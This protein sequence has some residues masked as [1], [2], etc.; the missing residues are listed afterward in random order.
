MNND[1]IK[2]IVPAIFEKIEKTF[3]LK[4]KESKIIKEKLKALKDNR[5]T[6]EDANDFAIELGDILASAFSEN[7]STK[8]LPDGK[9]YYNIAKR[10]IEPNM[11]K[12]YE[13]VGDYARIVQ[14]S[15]NKQAQISIKA[16]K[17]EINQD[18]IDKLVDKISEYESFEKGKWLLNEPIKNFTQAIVDDTIKKNAD[19]HYKAG[20]RPKIIRRE[21]WNCC[22][23]CKAIAGV[24]D[25]QEVKNTGNDVF[26]RHRHCRCTVDYVPGDGSKQDVWSKQ[27][28]DVNVDDKNKRIDLSNKQVNTKLS[29]IARAKALE[30]GYDPLPDDEV[31]NILRKDSQQWIKNLSDNEIKAIKKYT[32]NGVDF[33]G[34]RL[35]YKING[36]IEGYYDPMD[37]N[38]EELIKKIYKNIYTGILKNR[39]D[40]D[41][42]VYRK[43]EYPDRLEGISYKF[44]SASATQRGAFQ[45]NPNT[46][47]IVPKKSNGAYVENLSKFPK[48]REFLL[49]SGTYLEMIFKDKGTYI[50]KVVKEDE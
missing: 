46:A 11:I 48:Q 26:S 35:Y 18:R 32:Y 44:I 31:V 8:D 43:D 29:N 1:E 22:D 25:Y 6:Y 47:I 2:D 12:N 39:H 38:E 19:L 40:K 21:K 16:Q 15:L 10:L 27:W 24:Y 14:E 9:M 49:N 5:A 28:K 4:T 20:L 30:L 36:Y 34:K 23:W 3:K 7:I 41:I 50:Y 37:E 42:I 17:A 33:D 45:R 13:F